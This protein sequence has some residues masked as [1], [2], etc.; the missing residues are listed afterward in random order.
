MQ[1]SA[2]W[3]N[4]K[5]CNEIYIF[6]SSNK[7]DDIDSSLLKLRSYCLQ[8]W[9]L[10][11]FLCQWAI[12]GS[13]INH[14][15]RLSKTR[16]RYLS[17]MTCCTSSASAKLKV[18]FCTED[19]PAAY[20]LTKEQLKHDPDIHVTIH[21][22]GVLDIGFLGYVLQEGRYKG[23]YLRCCRSCSVHGETHEICP[24]ASPEA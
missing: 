21:S 8:P 13:L 18:L 6:I 16:P 14:G 23:S 15:L 17:R 19:F 20:E 11:M 12:R 7:I 3:A 2:W 9:N 1:V 22:K 10:S 4:A 24:S 5:S